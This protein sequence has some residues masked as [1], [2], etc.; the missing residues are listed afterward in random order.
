[1]PPA[2]LLHNLD[3]ASL[4]NLD[5]ADCSAS[6][7]RLC[8]YGCRPGSEEA[9]SP[10]SGLGQSVEHE[11]ECEVF[12][13]EHTDAS[14]LTLAP[15]GSQP[16]LQMRDPS[17]TNWVDV[18]KGLSDAGGDI[19]VFVGDFL[20]VLTKG[21]YVAARHRVTGERPVAGAHSPRRISMPF[22]VRGQ[23]GSTIDTAAYLDGLSQDIPL[24]RLQNMKYANLRRFLDLKGRHRFSGENLLSEAKTTS[25][26]GH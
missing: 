22:L 1:V 26:E 7:L 23:P 6:V 3:E 14:F 8:C 18:E 24:L 10:R 2:A 13:D 17:G 11:P 20:E 25:E 21:T 12:F 9:E 19:V 15:V 4:S 16:G 5:G